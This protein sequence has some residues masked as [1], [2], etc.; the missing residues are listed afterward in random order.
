MILQSLANYYDRKRQLEPHSVPPTGFEENAISFVVVLDP[1]GSFVNLEDWR[2]GEGKRKHGKLLFVPQSK[3]RTGKESWKTAFL[4][5]DH[6][7]YVFGLPKGGDDSGIPIKRLEAFQQ[8]VLAS[9]PDPQVDNG[10]NAVVL[11]YERPESL[12]RVRENE[13]WPQIEQTNGNISF[14]LRDSPELIC[15]SP[16]V[17]DA[18]MKEFTGDIG[19]GFGQCLITG[20]H[21]AIAELH[22]ATPVPGAKATAKL[23]SFNLAAFN[24]YGKAKGG[25]APVSKRAAFAYTTALNYLLGTRNRPANKQCIRIVDA[26]TV[27]WADKPSAME[28]NFA[29]IFDEPTKDDPDRNVRALKALYEAPQQGIVPI[30][31][32]QTRF[33]VL[34]LSPN[35]ARVAIRFWNVGTVA[36]LAGNIQQHFDDLRLVHGEREKPHLTLRS[37]LNATAFAT[38]KYPKGDPDKVFP[39]LSGEIMRAILE[40][41]PYPDTLLHGAVRRVR[42][43]QEVSYP[44]AAIV[45]ACLNRTR[46]THE[47]ELKMSLDEENTEVAYLL[48]RL[49][50]VLEEAQWAAHST[51]T[52]PGTNTTIRDRFYGAASATPITVF[53]QLLR[54]Y[55]HHIS[56]SAK[57]GRKGIA[58]RLEKLVDDITSKLPTTNPFPSYM[59]VSD[60]GRFAVGY[61]HQRH[62][63]FSSNHS[64]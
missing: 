20:Q 47:K 16:L 11:F 1:D 37:L 33:F 59:A 27:F 19:M 53:P 57:S 31:D 54:L 52:N 28:D 55:P 56:K 44:R 8:R 18:V 60:Q 25:N 10:V 4:L 43:E 9:F 14:R 49:F 15:Q 39:N 62:C 36:D 5:W 41:L 45:K 42:A 23:H 24:S 26:S 61:Y 50:F 46:M 7:R 17:R 29:D 6:P 21:E 34:G 2:E 32:N 35:M 30:K 40:R 48:G 58:V 3:D 38:A 63:F 64:A 51:K 12:Q 22:P 13:L